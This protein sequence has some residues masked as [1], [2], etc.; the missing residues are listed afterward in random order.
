MLSVKKLQDVMESMLDDGIEGISLM[1]IEGCLLCSAFKFEETQGPVLAA[2][3]S[4]IYQSF[5]QG[6]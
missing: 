6:I 1:T 3:S 5:L 4:S 2:I